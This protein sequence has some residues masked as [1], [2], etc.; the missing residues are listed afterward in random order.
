MPL[1]PRSTTMRNQCESLVVNK[2]TNKK[3]KPI[4]YEV[5]GQYLTLQGT[6]RNSLSKEPAGNQR[7]IRGLVSNV[8]ASV[9]RGCSSAMKKKEVRMDILFLFSGVKDSVNRLTR[10]KA[11]QLNSTRKTAQQEIKTEALTLDTRK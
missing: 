2:K 9:F 7:C 8:S 4:I 1:S 6:R 5:K 3:K 10:N 11:A